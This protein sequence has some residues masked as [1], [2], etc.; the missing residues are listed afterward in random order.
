MTSYKAEKEAFVSGTSGG[1]VLRI[2]LVCSTAIVC[3]PSS[4]MTRFPSILLS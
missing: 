1:S 2:N 4:L 3:F